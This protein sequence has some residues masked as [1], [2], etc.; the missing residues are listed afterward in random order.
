MQARQPADHAL[1]GG[2]AGAGRD[3]PT[4]I[5]EICRP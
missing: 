3:Y 2:A 5:M 4:A 1:S